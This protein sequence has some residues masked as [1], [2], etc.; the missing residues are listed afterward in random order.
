MQ[1][2]LSK[3]YDPKIPL[4]EQEFYELRLD[5]SDDI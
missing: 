3:T 4:R 2:V 1:E 5:D